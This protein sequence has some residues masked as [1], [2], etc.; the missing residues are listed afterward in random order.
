MITVG[1]KLTSLSQIFRALKMGLPIEAHLIYDNPYES[2]RIGVRCDVILKMTDLHV[3]AY[4]QLVGIEDDDC[5]PNDYLDMYY[6]YWEFWVVE[7]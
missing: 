1:S 4:N 7:R 6:S 2:H 5:G 3:S